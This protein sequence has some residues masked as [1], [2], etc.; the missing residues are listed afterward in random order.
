MP[1]WFVASRRAVVP[2]FRPPQDGLG[3]IVDVLYTAVLQIEGLD[4]Y[5][6]QAKEDL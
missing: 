5:A 6:P 2:R 4:R 3:R 1:L